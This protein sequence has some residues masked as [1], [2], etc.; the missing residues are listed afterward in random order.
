MPGPLS[1]A[2]NPEI[3]MR[4]IDRILDQMDRAFSGTPGTAR[5]S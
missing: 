2:S 1:Y 5:R 3:D 4:E